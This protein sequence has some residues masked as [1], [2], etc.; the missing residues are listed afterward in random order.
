MKKSILISAAF[1]LLMS[2]ASAQWQQTNGPCGGGIQCLATNDNS[3]VAGTYGGI[4]ISTDNGVTWN[5][6]NNGLTN[7]DIRSLAFSGT[8]I[9]AGSN[10][11]MFLSTD[12]GASWTP[13]DSGLAKRNDLP[14][15]CSLAAI[16]QINTNPLNWMLLDQKYYSQ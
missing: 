5:I 6:R 12:N 4:F 3:I 1:F 7:T 14:G 2:F 10:G 16:S 9:F 15:L 8:D 13:V 11:G